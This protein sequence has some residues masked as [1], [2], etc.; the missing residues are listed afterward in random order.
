VSKSQS[1]QLLADW[2]KSTNWATFGRV[3]ALTFGF[4][5]MLLLGYFFETPAATLG[6]LRQLLAEN[7]FDHLYSP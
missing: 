4:G 2:A 6:D 1:G 7:T 5:A 3:G